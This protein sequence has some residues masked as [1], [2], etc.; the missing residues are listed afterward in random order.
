MDTTTRRSHLRQRPETP[1][2][3]HRGGTSRTT[4]QEH[5]HE[6]AKIAHRVND[7][8]HR[9]EKFR[10]Y[11]GSTNSTRKSATGRDPKTVVD[12]SMLNHVIEIDV[13]K[14]T[15]LVE[16]NVPMDRLVEETLKSGLIPSVVMEFPG[17][18][19]GGG[20]SGTLGESSSFKHGFF[21]RTPK[22]VEM[23]LANGEIVTASEQNH[24]DLF[25]G[26]AGAVGTLGVTTMVEI[27]LR[28]ASKFVET[29]Y[30]PVSGIQHAIES[31]L[32][33]LHGRMSMTTL[34]E[35][36]FPKA[37]ERSSLAV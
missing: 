7:F 1:K 32:N 36:C 17:I 6:V 14:Q 11:H 20:Y 21:D 3:I 12:T 5:D 13:D 26:A 27:Q 15:V 23:V 24:S 34:T 2:G 9:K 4:I 31:C 29:T 37:A 18:T 35:F 10:I 30:L 33:S 19:V 25:H 8:F 16:P 22:R 28:K